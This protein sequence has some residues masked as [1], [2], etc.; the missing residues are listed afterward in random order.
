MG[1]HVIGH[2]GLERVSQRHL[3]FSFSLGLG[4]ILA[5][6]LSLAL[7]TYTYFVAI[8]RLPIAVALVIQFSATAWMTLGD[9]RNLV[10]TGQHR[11][12]VESTRL[13]VLARHDATS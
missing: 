3:C 2:V 12:W 9:E 7:V 6:G 4:W 11:Q 10:A 5:F 1:L 8:S 13:T